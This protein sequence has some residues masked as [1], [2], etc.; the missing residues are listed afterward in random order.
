MQAP[1]ELFNAEGLPVMNQSI[2]PVM[3]QPTSWPMGYSPSLFMPTPIQSALSNLQNPLQLQNLQNQNFQ[4]ANLQNPLANPLALNPLSNNFFYNLSQPHPS[5]L[6]APLVPMAEHQLLQQQFFQLQRQAQLQELKFQSLVRQQFA[7]GQLF[8]RS[9]PTG[10]I[11]AY[12][13]D[14]QSA[15]INAEPALAPPVPISR[16]VRVPKVKGQLC[17]KEG[18]TMVAQGNTDRCIGHGGGRRCTY[19]GCPRGARDRFFCAGHGGGKRCVAPNCSK[20]AVGATQCCTAH[21]GGRR[22]QQDGCSKSAQS[23]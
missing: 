20:S 11:N 6:T 17:S 13:A 3:N 15:H 16:P 19:M 23:A 22:C 10:M 8:D 1:T 9:L 5:M 18:C 7:D 4:S 14:I 2:L 21:G 12:Q